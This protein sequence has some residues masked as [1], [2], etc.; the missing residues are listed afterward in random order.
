MTKKRIVLAAVSLAG[1]LMIGAL[2]W[3]GCGT[4]T[5]ASVNGVGVSKAELD[6]TIEK[7]IASFPA[8]M[9]PKGKEGEARKKQLEK[10]AL[11]RLID[12]TLLTQ[13]ADK[14]G[15]SVPDS[16]IEK[17]I[18]DI[19]SRFPSEKQFNDALA[20][21]K[22]T[23]DDLKENI[24]SSVTVQRLM[25]KIAPASKV[26]DKEAL[27]FYK[28]NKSTTFNS[29]EQIHTRH[30]LV[31]KK[32]LA[33][34]IKKELDSGKDFATLAK[35]YSTDPGSK[36][37]GGDLGWS[38][39]GSFVPEYEKAALAL[40]KNGISQPVK[41]KFGYHVIQLLER[42]KG[43]ILSFKEVKDQ[44]KSMLS[45]QVRQEKLQKWLEGLRKKAKIEIE[46]ASL[47]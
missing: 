27:A 10:D 13:Q 34:K 35:K 2:V 40:E 33:D 12:K 3:S 39:L 46:D 11:N 29:Q 4:K 36:K 47:K 44:I 5:V 7:E 6:A 26:T 38:S 22:W 8:G 45:G 37:K 28:K 30:I 16:E 1:I 18:K 31:S 20:K 19:K 15:L 32:P 14:L 17:Q 23:L 24:K 25:D 43:R 42:K 41:S 21:Q 9:F